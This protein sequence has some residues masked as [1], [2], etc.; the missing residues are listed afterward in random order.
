MNFRQYILKHLFFVWSRSNIFLWVFP[1]SRI[2]QNMYI[3]NI[4]PL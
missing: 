1:K 2:C 3:Q 4:L